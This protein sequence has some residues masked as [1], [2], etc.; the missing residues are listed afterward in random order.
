MSGAIGGGTFARN[1]AADALSAPASGQAAVE[2]SRATK[3]LRRADSLPSTAPGDANGIETRYMGGKTFYKRGD[4]WTDAD[5]DVA[6]YPKPR[7]IKFGSTEY[8]TLARDA[9]TAKW[10]AVGEKIVFV[11]NG[12][13]IRIEP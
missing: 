3:T 1:G 8:W 12:E 11:S 13:A 6:K 2:A 5:Y 10:L 4:V 7:V 9:Q